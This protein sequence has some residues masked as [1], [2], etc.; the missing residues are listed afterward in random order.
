[1]LIGH[2]ITISPREPVCRDVLALAFPAAGRRPRYG[3]SSWLQKTDT[4]WILYVTETDPAW[5]EVEQLIPQ[6]RLG[7]HFFYNVFTDQELADASWFQISA[8]GHHGYPQ[9]QDGWDQVVYSPDGGCERCGIHGKQISPFRLR[10]EPKAHK[11]DFVQL[12][13]VF[14]EFFVRQKARLALEE[15]GITGFQWLAPVIHRSGEPSADV[16]QMVIERVLPPALS[17]SDLTFEA[18]RAGAPHPP[19]GPLYPPSRQALPH[20]GRVKYHR[21]QRGPLEFDATCLVDL[22]DIVKTNEWFGSGGSADRMLLCSSR[23]RY[24]VLDNGLRGLD[25]EPVSTVG[26]T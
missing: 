25:F 20:C 22:P 15:A 6:R 23:F 26:P 12:N 1:V 17:T 14:G 21:M 4:T 3:D 8:L 19:P 24:A 10:S 2:R 5:P 7:T 9:P 13:W 18:C 11:S 16:R